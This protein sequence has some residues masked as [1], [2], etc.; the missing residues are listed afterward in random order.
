M[1]AMLGVSLLFIGLLEWFVQR[2][3]QRAIILTL[4]VSIA[5][6]LN[7]RAANGFRHD[8]QEQRNFFW[9]LYWRA[10]FIQPGTALILE[11]D[12]SPNNTLFSISS[13]INYMYPQEKNPPRLGYYLY[14]LRPRWS[15]LTLAPDEINF[16]TKFRSFSFKTASPNSLLFAYDPSQKH[17]LWLVY[18]DERVN[19]Y[20]PDL[21]ATFSRVS[22]PG[23][24]QAVPPQVSYPPKDIF[25]QEPDPNW[26]YYFEKAD[27][28]RQ[29]GDW[30]TVIALVEQ[31]NLA[32]FKPGVHPDI[33]AY[34]WAPF[35]EGYAMAGHWQAAADL[36]MAAY[37]YDSEAKE[38]YCYLWEKITSSVPSSKET[39]TTQSVLAEL[40]CQP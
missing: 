30:Q 32:G 31:A 14:A 24:I 5:M 21:V 4:L 37:Q 17:C 23:R 16:S 29:T 13:A 6:V 7:L 10:P 18:P 8:W 15:G 20:L 26:C 36:T 9:Q 1:A 19:P 11:E 40:S 22:N 2:R 27:L 28:A 33:P 3:A 39:K 25:G 38:M 12:P 35:I 34:E